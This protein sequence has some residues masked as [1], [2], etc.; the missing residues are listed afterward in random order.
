MK[1][2]TF[3]LCWLLSF[4]ASAYALDDPARTS[5]VHQLERDIAQNPRALTTYAKL[6]ELGARADEVSAGDFRNVVQRLRKR[7]RLPAHRDYLA[8]LMARAWLRQGELTQSQ[9]QWDALGYLSRWRVHG[10]LPNDGDQEFARE[11]IADE[12]MQSYRAEGEGTWR[13][14]APDYAAF[15]Y[16]GVGNFVRPKGN[17]C[18]LA[19]TWV[20][21]P[22]AEPVVLSVGASGAVRLYW[23]TQHVLSDNIYRSHALPDSHAVQVTPHVGWNQVV[24][25]I[26]TRT[27]DTPST[28]PNSVWGVYLRVV[29]PKGRA[30]RD[31]RH[32][33]YP[34]PST[35]SGRKGVWTASGVPPASAAP[36]GEARSAHPPLPKPT[37]LE[38]LCRPD[39]VELHEACARVL[40]F[41]RADDRTWSLTLERIQSAIA[42]APS[43]DLSVLA[44]HITRERGEKLS[45][46]KQALALDAHHAEA[47]LAL[48]HYE[49]NGF[50][51]QSANTWLTE[52]YAVRPADAAVA[53]ASMYLKLGLPQR[54]CRALEPLSVTAPSPAILQSL[55]AC[56]ETS[57]QLQA[58]YKTYSALEST[59]F[60]DPAVHRKLAETA[61][62]AGD[63]ARVKSELE[64]LR[65]VEAPSADGF[66]YRARIQRAMGQPQ[67][68][69]ATLQEASA[70]I[71]D[72][73][74]VWVALGR[75]YLELALHE[76][77]A[78]AL[79]TAL[80]LRPQD[81]NVRE[82]LDQLQPTS[83]PDE[84]YVLPL[85]SILQRRKTSSAYPFEYLHDLTVTTVF[86]NGLSGTFHQVA[87][88]VHNQEGV[89]QW[90]GFSFG[91]DPTSE[92]PS[93]RLARV[94]HADGSVSSAFEID[95][96]SLAESWY[97]M[98]FDHRSFIVTFPELRPGDVIEIQFRVDDV[99]QQNLFS[100]Y[101]GSLQLLQSA[102]PSAEI[103]YLWLTPK[104]RKLHV[105]VPSHGVTP[106][107]YETKQQRIY[108][109]TVRNAAAMPDEQRMPGSTEIAPYAHVSTY[110]SWEQMGRWYWGL[111]RDQLVANAAIRATTAKLVEGLTDSPEDRKAKVDRIYRWVVNHTRYVGLEFGIHSHKP[112]HVAE[113]FRR[114]F[115]DCKD[116]ASLMWTMLR[117]A[118]V[119]AAMAL[120]R[121]RDD[122]MVRNHPAS[123]AVFNHVITY[124]PEFDWF[125]D[126]TAEHTDSREL[127]DQDQ[128]VITLI[129]QPDAVKRTTTPVTLA[130][131]N[132]RSRHLRIALDERGHATLQGDER[133]SGT[134]ASAF[135]Q[136][137]EA[138]ATRLQRVQHQ[139][140]ALVRGAQIT[141]VQVDA[142][143]ESSSTSA[144][145]QPFHIRY[146]G[147]VRDFAQ[148]DQAARKLPLALDT[149]L[150]RSLVRAPTRT[151][152]MEIGYAQ[153]YRE[154]I[155][156]TLPQGMRVLSLPASRTN[157]SAFGVVELRTRQQGATL[158]VTTSITLERDKITAGEYPAF[159]QWLGAVE[160][161]SQQPIEYQRQ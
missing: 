41:A 59:R 1:C 144:R 146:R 79:K 161:W 140:E 36:T 25:K 139:M 100:N 116:K 112:Y 34:E 125:L 56:Y 45:W 67:Q 152:P 44:S 149:K 128:G 80:R 114:G 18:G 126:A 115:G 104:S 151:T 75:L 106:K 86:E 158:T 30:V 50:T 148:A 40:Y 62:A 160:A 78:T 61:L 157:R 54:A 133:I 141:D 155:E 16:L 9:A 99:A 121:T 111:I 82:L 29:T 31:L 109:Y 13:R 143:S 71:G 96:Q 73:P 38:T 127:P 21:V 98:Y 91:F 159:R 55:A 22:R 103:R 72:E 85:Q 65:R 5:R 6:V 120:V 64:H 129:V 145:L 76:D 37:P 147:F 66:L 113:V 8:V 27:D 95:E 92:Q 77:A 89:E 102:V 87:V 119:P 46:L 117:E 57:G 135:R 26:C 74:D 7:L 154:T 93:V 97:K 118:G 58:A 14:I 39:D 3:L 101:Y 4:S 122:G 51:P 11:S 52:P 137:Y 19:E 108:D 68:A 33:A 20:F 24:A 28:E 84:Q 32:A 134:A 138:P 88:Q 47:A 12:A 150:F 90:R 2:R 123:L 43:A 124:V 136:H 81:K 132:V 142:A 130:R 69:R 15:G 35:A 131:D 105:D 23:N 156:Y 53:H 60:D 110:E 153:T 42:H 63:M 107:V 10:V 94:V 49:L 83:R 48:A 17:V 70:L